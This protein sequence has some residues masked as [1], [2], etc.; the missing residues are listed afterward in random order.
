MQNKKNAKYKK[1]KIVFQKFKL[2]FIFA[3]GTIKSRKNLIILE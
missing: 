1:M 2:T 3:K